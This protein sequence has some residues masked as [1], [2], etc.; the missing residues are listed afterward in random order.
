MIAR[1]SLDPGLPPHVADSDWDMVNYIINS[2]IR[3]RP[4]TSYLDVQAAIWFFIGPG[5]FPSDI[6]AQEMVADA[7]AN[8]EGFIP[9]SGD[10]GA[11]IMDAGTARQVT[12]IEVPCSCVEEVSGDR[13]PGF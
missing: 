11:V 7:L 8:G 1:G 9:G 6:D 3:S 13:P 10:L 5:A 12:F 2:N 4:T